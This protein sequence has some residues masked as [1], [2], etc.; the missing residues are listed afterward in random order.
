MALVELEVDLASV[1]VVGKAAATQ[2][3]EHTEEDVPLS[4]VLRVAGVMRHILDRERL[5]VARERVHVGNGWHLTTD[6]IHDH[7]VGSVAVECC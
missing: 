4:G 2:I 7:V 1:V 6:D 5:V 3:V